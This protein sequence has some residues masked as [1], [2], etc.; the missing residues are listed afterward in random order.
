MDRNSADP[1]PTAVMRIKTATGSRQRRQQP[2]ACIQT[3]RRSQQR[4]PRP[5]RN[6][7]HRRARDAPPRIARNDDKEKPAG[8]AAGFSRLA[9]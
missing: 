6:A 4:W 8:F 7:I 9:E 3:A 2:H 1:L 5:E